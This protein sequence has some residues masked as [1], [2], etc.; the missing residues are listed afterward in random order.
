L[1]F[2]LLLFAQQP[3]RLV[4]STRHPVTKKTGKLMISNERPSPY[5]RWQQQRPSYQSTARPTFA[6]QFSKPPTQETTV[7]TERLQ[8]ERKCFVIALKENDR[9]QFLRIVEES[10]G[11]RD[12]LII[13]STGLEDFS[14]IL[15]DMVSSAAQLPAE[16]QAEA[17]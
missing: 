12:M 17:Q 2:L 9:G 16:A 10:N 5:G 4:A 13:P 3:F 7:R 8:V 6:K 11:H 14:K 1:K 15:T